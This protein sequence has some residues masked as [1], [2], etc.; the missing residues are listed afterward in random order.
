MKR[1]TQ[2]AA[3]TLLAFSGL[4]FAANPDD[5]TANDDKQAL[6]GPRVEQQQTDERPQRR[7]R[8]GDGELMER[9]EQ[10]ARAERESERRA[11]FEGRGQQVRE[12]LGALRAL[13]NADGDLALSEGQEAQIK[14]I[15]EEHREAVKAYMDEHK[16]EIE[17][18][19]AELKPSEE[20]ERPSPEARKAA[21]EK[22]KAIMDASPAD[23]SAKQKIMDVLSVGQQ[24]L[25]KETI[26]KQRERM[27]ARQK[28]AAQRGGEGGE[29]PAR[30]DGAAERPERPERMEGDAPRRERPRPAQPV[31]D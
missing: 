9:G 14:K 10:H 23:G 5:T 28:R 30:R 13:K 12:M 29:R 19:R 17:S 20:G 1:T 31:D 7:M 3:M 22:V 8:G 25:V 24:D 15:A 2:L 6:K 4:A 21:M 18:I 27:E 16:D 26:K 11:G